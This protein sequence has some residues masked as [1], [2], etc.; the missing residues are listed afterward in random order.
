[1]ARHRIER[2][3][4]ILK[5]ELSEMIRREFV[6]DAPLVTVQHVDCTQD[7][8]N[9]NVY[10]SVLGTEAQQRKALAQIQGKRAPLQ[11]AL[12]R[13]VTLKYTPQIH[14]KLDTGIERGTKIIQLMDELD[15]L[16]ENESPKHENPPSD[17][18]P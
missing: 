6:F 11:Y 4:E 2:V 10:L 13:R 12:S 3:N 7:L 5:R 8:K 9:A 18:A 1:M 16:P 14:F 15:L 17:P